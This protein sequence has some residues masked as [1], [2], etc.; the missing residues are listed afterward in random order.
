MAEWI[1]GGVAASAVAADVEDAPNVGGA[2]GAG[3]AELCGWNALDGRSKVKDPCGAGPGVVVVCAGVGVTGPAGA[4]ADVAGAGDGVGPELCGWYEPSGAYELHG[5]ADEKD[6]WRAGP[7]VGAWGAVG[8]KPP[9]DSRKA[10]NALS[11]VVC[12][13]CSGPGPVAVCAGVGAAPAGVV[14]VFG[15]PIVGASGVGFGTE[16]SSCDRNELH[17]RANVKDPCGAGPAAAV[18]LAGAGVA[19]VANEPNVAGAEGVAGAPNVGAV[20][21]GLLGELEACPSCAPSES[22][23]SELSPPVAAAS[24]LALAFLARRPAFFFFV[25]AVPDPGGGGPVGVPSP[26][27]CSSAMATARFCFQFDVD[28]ECV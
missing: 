16:L 8:A 1:A 22:S 25:A 14:G 26:G 10:R 18:V 27:S 15:A 21:G 4:A 6:P 9:R 24:A 2:V 12:R 17:S 19:C 28:D 23:D 3:V 7:V 13:S 11:N 20:G 5:R